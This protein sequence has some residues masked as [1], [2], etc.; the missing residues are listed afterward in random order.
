MRPVEPSLSPSM[1]IQV[2]SN[3]ERLLFELLDRDG[4]A[5]A[6]AMAA[7]RATGRMPVPEQAWKRLHAVFHGFRLDD[8]GTLAEIR[9]LHSDKRLPR[10]PAYRDRHRRRPR[11]RLPAWRA[12]GRDGHG[13]SGKVPRRDGAG[14][15]HAPPSASRA[16]PTYMN[17]LRFFRAPPTTSLLSRR[18]SARVV[19]R[20]AA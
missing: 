16:S 14:D 11:T 18:W 17:V 1:D 3:F 15:R 10:R 8:A 9:R 20:N 2:S 5:T 6:A 19:L 4:E 12:D 13:A 7:F